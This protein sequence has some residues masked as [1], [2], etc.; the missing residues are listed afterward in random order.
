MQKLDRIFRRKKILTPGADV[1]IAIF[2]E[3]LTFFSKTNVMINFLNNLALFR[4]KNANFCAKF[5]GENIF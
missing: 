3:K 4:I 1:M 2:G 5:F